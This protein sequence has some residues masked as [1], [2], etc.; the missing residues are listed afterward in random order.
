MASSL[1]DLGD[2]G[3]GEDPRLGPKRLSGPCWRAGETARSGVSAPLAMRR[4]PAVHVSAISFWNPFTPVLHA[5]SCL[6]AVTMA[7]YSSSK[8]PWYLTVYLPE[9]LCCV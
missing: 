1:P 9:V 3:S 5:T 6:D 4:R 7:R 8:T 2:V